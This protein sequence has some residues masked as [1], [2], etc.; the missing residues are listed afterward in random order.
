MLYLRR[1]SAS[2]SFCALQTL[3]TT[4]L[5]SRFFAISFFASDCL[6]GAMSAI[7]STRKIGSAESPWAGTRMI[8]SG[9]MFTGAEELTQDGGEEGVA[10]LLWDPGGGDEEHAAVANLAHVQHRLDVVKVGDDHRHSLLEPGRQI[11]KIIM[12]KEKR[13]KSKL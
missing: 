13:R 8:R 12:K 1:L 7:S 9:L 6:F 4:N 2:D 3:S 5:F 11:A 10:P